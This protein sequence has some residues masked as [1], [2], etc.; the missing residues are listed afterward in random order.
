M[1]CKAGYHVVL[2]CTAALSNKGTCLFVH[3]LGTQPA[4]QTNPMLEHKAVVI[5]PADQGMDML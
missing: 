5:Q 3:W 2:D 1:R 4:L